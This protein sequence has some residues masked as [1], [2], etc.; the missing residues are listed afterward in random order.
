VEEVEAL[1]RSNAKKLLEYR[2]LDTAGSLIKA[3]HRGANVIWYRLC[4][5]KKV[6]KTAEPT[7]TTFRHLVEGSGG[8][9]KLCEW[10]M[11][12]SPEYAPFLEEAKKVDEQ[13]DRE[14]RERQKKATVEPARAAKKPKAP[15]SMLASIDVT[16]PSMPGIDAR[17]GMPATRRISIAGIR[18]LPPPMY[19]ASRMDWI[20]AIRSIDMD[21]VDFWPNYAHISQ[22]LDDPSPTHANTAAGGGGRFARNRLYAWWEPVACLLECSHWS[23][24]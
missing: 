17:T 23:K 10:V 9:P 6:L 16:D 13:R 14:K 11:E 1:H 7:M 19:N 5:I 22:A 20:K 21:P 8:V 15:E 12:E 3:D 18:K 4:M 2:S 24:A